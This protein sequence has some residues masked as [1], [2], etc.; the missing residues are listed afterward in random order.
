MKKMFY[1]GCLTSVL[2]LSACSQISSQ[3]KMT[4][5]QATATSSASKKMMG[6]RKL[7]L[8]VQ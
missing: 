2:L 6:L 1:L 5:S 3:Q 8:P 7:R 4:A